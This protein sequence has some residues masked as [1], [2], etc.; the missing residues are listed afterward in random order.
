[1]PTETLLS[2]VEGEKRKWSFS[3]KVYGTAN[4]FIRV[5]LICASSVVAAD[6]TIGAATT[7]MLAQL[8]QWV[9]GLA[10]GVTIVTALDTWLKPRDKWRGFM[11]DRDAITDLL[12]RVRKDAS[13]GG[14]AADSLREEFLKLRQQHRE[15]NV[16]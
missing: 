1:M 14:A 5:F 13:S 7:S 9:P 8:G 10:L 15:K 16:Y 4:V 2:E 3:T 12:I 6:K 11:E